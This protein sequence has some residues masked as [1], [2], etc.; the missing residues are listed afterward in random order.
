MRSSFHASPLGLLRAISVAAAL[1][2]CLAGTALA[3]D[4]VYIKPD[5]VDL[6]RLIPPA[7]TPNSPTTAEDFRVLLEVQAKRTPAEVAAA[8]VDLERTLSRFSAVTG[9][10][11][12]PAKAPIANAVFDRAWKQAY[13]LTIAAKQHWHRKRPYLANP[14]IQLAVP[15]ENTASYPSGH[16]TWGMLTAILLADILPE[17]AGV[18]FARGQ[19]YGFERV[20][21]GVHYPS[22]VAAGRIAGSVLAA[23][24]LR[25]PQMQDDLKR[26][27][28]E[29]R[30]Q[31]GLPPLTPAIQPAQ[32]PDGA[33]I[34]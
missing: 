7:P 1:S 12:S 13:V 17:K 9:A 26:A 6:I 30:P 24:L 4:P 14:A 31:L 16:S 5:D 32:I 10:D 29:I 18:I 27:A 15:A 34:D 8:N 20:I 19:Q 21:G 28:E 33:A 22:D 2:V 25:N 11:L 3:A 23:A